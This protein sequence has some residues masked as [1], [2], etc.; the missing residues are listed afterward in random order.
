LITIRLLWWCLRLRING[1]RQW[2]YQAARHREP[3]S[4]NSYKELPS[5]KV[6]VM[7]HNVSS[8]S[9]ALDLL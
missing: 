5:I 7:L 9:F 1:A 4:T 2:H 3:D 8:I 6:E